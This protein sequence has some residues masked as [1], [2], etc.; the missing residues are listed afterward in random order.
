MEVPKGA[1]YPT[2]TLLPYYVIPYR[3]RATLNVV[4]MAYV[5]NQLTLLTAGKET[6]KTYNYLCMSQQGACMGLLD[7]GDILEISILHGF[8]ER[9]DFFF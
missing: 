5:S 2:T 4:Q 8:Q 3:L 6:M 9:F 7:S 1:S